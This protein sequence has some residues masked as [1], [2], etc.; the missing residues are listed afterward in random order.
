MRVCLSRSRRGF[1]LIELLVVIAIIAVLIGLLLPAVQK[2]RE[3][4]ARM[5]CSNNL[6]QLGLGLHNYHDQSQKLPVGEI[7]NDGRNWGWGTYVLP[8]IEQDPL[9]RQIQSSGVFWTPPGGGGG[10]N[11]VS[12]DSTP[13]VFDINNLPAASNLTPKLSV[14]M[15]PSDIL[16]EMSNARYGKTNYLANI[17]NG[18]LSA[19][20]TT[21]SFGC[22]TPKGG[23]QNGLMPY[24]HDDNSTWTVAFT[25]ITDG[26]SNTIL[27]G[28][29]TANDQFTVA[30]GRAPIWAGGNPDNA[31]CS[32]DGVANYFRT[33]EIG[34]TLNMK[35]T[36]TSRMCYGSQHSGGAMFLLGDGSVR[37]VRDSI[38]PA[39]YKAVGTRNGGETLSFD[40]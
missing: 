8:F 18:G 13:N 22:G 27:L 40:N 23:A 32:Y 36:T 11:G 33:T 10:P 21:A 24:A 30:N 17:G 31:G 9:Y 12:T 28:E 6:K 26:L 20:W 5:K 3:A 19:T 14:F 2:V 16:P 29:G 4:A 39:A 35:T 38:T 1:T 25:A 7:D 34:F 37:F 15:C